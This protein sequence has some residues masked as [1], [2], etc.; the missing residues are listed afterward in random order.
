[1]P[2]IVIEPGAR[3][4]IDFTS[5][6]T[7][8][9][10]AVSYRQCSS[11]ASQPLQIQYAGKLNYTPFIGGCIYVSLAGL[12]HDMGFHAVWMLAFLFFFSVSFPVS[13]LL[14]LYLQ[15]GSFGF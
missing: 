2:Q 5:E 15:S 14:F 4:S 3:A 10:F 12:R 11:Q 9:H 6:N 7:S 1:M 13:T 8:D